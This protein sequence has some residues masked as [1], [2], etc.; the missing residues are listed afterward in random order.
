MN[1]PD[2]SSIRFDYLLLIIY[3]KSLYVIVLSE[4]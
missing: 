3:Q 4:Y 2:C 1:L